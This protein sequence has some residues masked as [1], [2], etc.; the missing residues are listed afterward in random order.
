MWNDE[1]STVYTSSSTSCGEQICFL[2][3]RILYLGSSF[4][5]VY[6][7]ELCFLGI[8]W[9]G[10]KQLMNI[11]VYVLFCRIVLDWD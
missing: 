1:F 6:I 10:L 11:I 7:P 9:A 3:R 8:N 5:E 4:Y 2:T